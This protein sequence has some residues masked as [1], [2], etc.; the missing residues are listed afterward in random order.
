MK[1]SRSKTRGMAR[2]ATEPRP[3]RSTSCVRAEH[4][5]RLISRYGGFDWIVTCLGF[6]VQIFVAIVS[7]GIPS[8]TT[9]HKWQAQSGSA[10]ST[11]R[12]NPL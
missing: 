7:L 5:R 1:L 4:G 2:E 11:D 3:L 6:A 8:S 9:M 10:W 12:F